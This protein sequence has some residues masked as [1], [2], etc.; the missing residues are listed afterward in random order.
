MKSP[1]TNTENVR[2]LKSVPTSAIIKKYAKEL[3]IDVSRFFETDTIQIFECLDTGYKFYYPY[4]IS[5]DDKLYEDLQK[6]GGY[7]STWK[8]EHDM[9]FAQIKTDDKVLEVGC[10][11][12][13]FI[14]KLKAAKINCYGLELNKKAVE[15]CRKKG[16]AVADE[17]LEEHKV[18]H[19]NFYDVVCSFQVLEHISDVRSYINDSID[20]TKVGGKIIFGV[21][22]NNPFIYKRDVYHTLNLPPH[23]M[24][25][26]S[27]EAFKKLENY[28]N[29]K[30]VD[31][32]V[33]QL[34]EVRQYL[35]TFLDYNN[36]FLLKKITKHIPAIFIRPVSKIRKWK[37]RN[38]IGIYEKV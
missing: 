36:L 16:L 27:E 2:F 15:V 32:K 19:S 11:D 4:N 17:L 34:T 7:Y 1:V 26:W 18:N 29:M 9:A 25:L 22:N 13:G 31:V 28:Y 14:S 35:N 3:K 33:D 23:H 38:L 21:P 10:G 8:W 30:L 24:G 5:G 12:G 37:G 6:I 20:V